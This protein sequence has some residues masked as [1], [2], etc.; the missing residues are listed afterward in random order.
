MT[1]PALNVLLTNNATLNTGDAAILL[2]TMR[3]LEHAYGQPIRYTVRDQQ[4][5]VAERHYP[6]ICFRPWPHHNMWRPPPV[7]RIG[8]VL[9]RAN[10]ARYEVGIWAAADGRPGRFLLTRAERTDAAEYARADLVISTGGTY[11]VENYRLEPLILDLQLAQRMRRPHVLFTQSMGPFTQP[12]TSKVLRRILEGADLVLLRDARSR[13]HVEALGAVATLEVTADSAFALADEATLARAAAARSPQ[14]DGQP[15]RVAV[16]VREW[17]H[18]ATVDPAQGMA[19][20]R[21]AV[22]ELVTH[23]VQ[24]RGAQ[25]VFVSTCQGVPEYW[26]DDARVAGEIVALLEPSVAEQVAVDGEFRRP[27]ALLE[28]LSGYD[29]VVSTR[30]HLA[31]LALCTGVPVLPISYEFKTDELFAR[32]GVGDWV[33]DIECATGPGLIEAVDGFLSALPGLRRDLFE[34]VNA[35]RAAALDSGLRARAAVERRD[36]AADASATA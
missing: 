35:E 13:E 32:L 1:A 9:R 8:R 23:L 2:G 33:Q 34:R 20:F 10:R 29:L 7:P 4:P 26:T 28:L 31:I 21:R 17:R 15:L 30:M 6:E 12:K 22:A 16:S 25:V 19:S 5:E 18:F 11:L 36:V 3:I 24:R 14:G 27:E